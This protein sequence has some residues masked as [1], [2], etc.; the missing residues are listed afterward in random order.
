M[1]DKEIVVKEDMNVDF[2][3]RELDLGRTA[4]LEGEGNCDAVVVL[5]T[6][7]VAAGSNAT[8]FSFFVAETTISGTEYVVSGLNV[9][10]HARFDMSKIWRLSTSQMPW[11][12]QPPKINISEPLA[13]QV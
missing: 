4:E 11:A 13:W 1:V 2:E 10:C 3:G 9:L 8:S 6:R 5:T 12:V 7:A